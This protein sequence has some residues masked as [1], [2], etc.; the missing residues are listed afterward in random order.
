MKLGPAS[1]EKY[2]LKLIHFNLNW[3]FILIIS[4]LINHLDGKVSEN[5]IPHLSYFVSFLICS[6][7]LIMAF[8]RIDR[9]IISKTIFTIIL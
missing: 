5:I 9:I 1:K 6:N 7:L 8:Y 2:F 4:L 3:L